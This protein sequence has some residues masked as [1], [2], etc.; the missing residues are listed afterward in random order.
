MAVETQGTCFELKIF[1]ESPLRPKAIGHAHREA[2]ILPSGPQCSITSILKGALRSNEQ[3]RGPPQQAQ[4]ACRVLEIF[5]L[6]WAIA[7]MLICKHERAPD[8]GLVEQP[9]LTWYICI[10]D[11]AG[12]HTLAGDS[13]SLRLL[14][15]MTGQHGRTS[16]PGSSCSFVPRY[17]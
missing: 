7:R 16:N 11:G 5:Q 14:R 13:K 10:R 1:Q 3:L 2:V 6:A 12:K 17:K 15:T 8:S 4:D 9:L